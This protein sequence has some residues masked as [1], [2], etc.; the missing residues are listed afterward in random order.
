ME[1]KIP[2]NKTQLLPKYIEI[3]QNINQKKLF[4]VNQKLSQNEII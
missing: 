4:F 1:N 3:K 2:Q